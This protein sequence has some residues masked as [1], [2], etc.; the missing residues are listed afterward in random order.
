MNWTHLVTLG[1]AAGCL[2]ADSADAQAFLG[3]TP[4]SVTVRPTLDGSGPSHLFTRGR[5]LIVLDPNLGVAIRYPLDANDKLIDRP[6]ACSMPRNFSPRFVLPRTAGVRV[7]GEEQQPGLEPSNARLPILELADSI[8]Q[9]MAAFD[10]DSATRPPSCGTVRIQATT[11]PAES[12]ST[13]V[14]FVVSPVAGTAAPAKGGIKVGPDARTELFNARAIGDGNGLG[15]AIVRR[16]IVGGEFGRVNV[17][18]WVTLYLNGRPTSIW[19]KEHDLNGEG[20]IV[21][22]TKRG[23]DYA[24]VTGHS[25]FIMG[26]ICPGSVCIRRFDLTELNASAGP[27]NNWVATID[28]TKSGK[29]SNPEDAPLAP[30][31]TAD[32]APELQ[33]ASAPRAQAWNDALVSAVSAYAFNS[34]SYPPERRGVPCGAD[35][36]DQ[37]RLRLRDGRLVSTANKLPTDV[38]IPQEYDEPLDAKWIGPRNLIDEG[39]AEPPNAERGIPY[40]FGG[41]TKA[42]DFLVAIGTPNGRPIGHIRD[43]LGGVDAANYPVGIDC[44]RFVWRIFGELLDTEAWIDNPPPPSKARFV[45]D[46]RTARPGDLLVKKGHIVIFNRRVMSG[47]NLTVE[48]FEATSRCGRACRSVYDADFFNGWRIMRLRQMASKGRMSL[49]NPYWPELVKAS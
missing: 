43:S 33:D 22:L 21:G 32:A 46:L 49:D 38:F 26:T 45:K 36:P 14:G 1:V 37:C 16:E 10:R 4:D 3:P 31:E 42:E 39:K 28:L 13:S 48:V 19:L 25:L 7:I 44:S 23:F 27:R 8:L 18:V 20:K 9:T 47:A 30:L 2:L 35:G 6:T 41:S 34:W 12:R 17:A 11:I 5:A 24:A 40:S 29:P 15:T